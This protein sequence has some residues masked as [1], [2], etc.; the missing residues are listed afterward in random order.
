M[1][2]T[3]VARNTFDG[4]SSVI[5]AAALTIG[6]GGTTIVRDNLFVGNDGTQF[7][8]VFSWRSVG[9]IRGNTFYGNMAPSSG[10]VVFDFSDAGSGTSVVTTNNIFVANLGGPAYRVQSDAPE[11]SCNLFWSNPGG[12]YEGYV[13]SPTDLFV[14]PLFCDREGGDFRLMS[15]S[16]CLPENSGTCGLIGAF[17]QGC[18][19]VAV[20]RSSWGAIKNRFR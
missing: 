6:V 10:G 15:D 1:P 7:R 12:D 3:E 20:E 9:E 5:N 11:A 18:G 19:T 13:P 2:Q 14:D 8:G 17:G 4:N 16:P